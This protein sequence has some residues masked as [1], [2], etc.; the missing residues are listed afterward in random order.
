MSVRPFGPQV[1]LV[2]SYLIL[3]L[4]V[5]ILHVNIYDTCK[6]LFTEK[7]FKDIKKKIKKKKRHFLPII[8]LQLRA[9]NQNN[10]MNGSRDLHRTDARTNERELI[11]PN[12]S[13]GDQK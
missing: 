10:P 7:F 12:R 13:A 9:E 2:F 3:S 5:L 1:C 6:E 8:E 4:F 11:G